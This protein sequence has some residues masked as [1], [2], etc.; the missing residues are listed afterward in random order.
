MII[1]IIT[2]ASS[3]SESFKDSLRT[4][5]DTDT[6][7][8]YCSRQRAG[9]ENAFASLTPETQSFSRTSESQ[10]ESSVKT[11]PPVFCAVAVRSLRTVFSPLVD[12]R[13]NR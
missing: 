2:R 8:V 13:L 12:V 7:S 6:S 4:Y 10:R 1:I 11:M 5:S 3:F 9:R